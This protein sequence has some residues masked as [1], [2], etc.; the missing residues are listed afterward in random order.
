MINVSFTSST[1]GRFEGLVN[2]KTSREAFII[3]VEVTVVDGW[4]YLLILL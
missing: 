3:H 1:P 2:F 4:F